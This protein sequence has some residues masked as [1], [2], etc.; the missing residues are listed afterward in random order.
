MTTAAEALRDAAAALAAASDTARL[1]AE[2]LLAHALG[3]TRSDLLLRHRDT[4]A[5]EG[6]AALIARRMAHEPVAYI[7]GEAEFYGRRFIVTRK[8]L[9]PRG[10]SE[11]VVTAAL[12]ACPAPRRVLDC[13]VGSGCLLLTILAERPDACGIGIDRSPDALEIARENAIALEVEGEWQLKL[14]D[15][16]RSGWSD[17]LG[18]FD[19]VVANVPYIENDADLDPSVRDHEPAGALFA[20]A[21]GLDD[22]RVL[23]PQLSG[24]LAPGGVAALEI[25]HRQA[26]A[27]GAIARRAGLAANV[28]QDL[29]GRDRVLTLRHEVPTL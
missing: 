28:R 22:Y 18:R 1:D 23:I 2:L 19:L 27:V 20:G 14:A 26:D 25:G 12:E 15:W 5:P 3:V 10:D 21:D 8:V 9:I 17:G 6:F 16:T 4:P 11:P 24:L 7:L 29:G 13:G